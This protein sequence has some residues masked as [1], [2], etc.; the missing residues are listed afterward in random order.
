MR[1]WK[2]RNMRSVYQLQYATIHI[3]DYVEVV[4]PFITYIRPGQ[5]SQNVAIYNSAGKSC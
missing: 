5:F 1:K 2:S 3:R 4:A